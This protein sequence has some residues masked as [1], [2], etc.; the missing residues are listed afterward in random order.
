MQALVLIIEEMSDHF[1]GGV[2]VLE[3]EGTVFT[4]NSFNRP[5]TC[6]VIAPPSRSSRYRDYEET[7]FFKSMKRCEGFGRET[8]LKGQCVIDIAKNETD[9]SQNG[10][11]DFLQGTHVTV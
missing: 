2:L 3:I 8:P 9:R 4:N 7:R 1:P 5:K 11:W 6:D 10:L